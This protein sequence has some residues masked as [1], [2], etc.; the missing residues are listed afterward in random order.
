M[1]GLLKSTDAHPSAQWLYERMKPEFPRLSLSTVY[2]NLDILEREG[3][4]QRLTCGSAE[5]RYDGNT[6]SHSHFFCRL[7]GQVFDVD[8]GPV[9]QSALERAQRCAHSLEGC[10]VTYYGVCESCRKAGQNKK[11]KE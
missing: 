6:A 8:F 7:C 3:E 10:S 2:R 5:G 1:L 9:E 4:L 11:S